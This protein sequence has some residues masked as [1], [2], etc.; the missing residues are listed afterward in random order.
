MKDFV[1]VS[2]KGVNKIT[3]IIRCLRSSQIGTLFIQLILYMLQG[4]PMGLS[5]SIPII[6][7]SNKISIE[8]L[9]FFSIVTLPFSL[10]IL[11]API[12]DCLYFPQVGR[13]KCWLIPTQIACGLLMIFTGFKWGFWQWIQSESLIDRWVEPSEEGVAPN[14]MALSYLFLCYYFLMATQDIAVDAW[15]VSMLSAGNEGLASTMNTIGQS[16]GVFIGNSLFVTFK[17]TEFMIPFTNTS[18]GLLTLGNFTGCCG[19]LMIFVS[20]L[21]IFKREECDSTDEDEYEL[22]GTTRKEKIKNAYGCLWKLAQLSPIKRLGFVLIVIQLP[23]SC[24]D[25]LTSLKLIE[26]GISKEMMAM[27]SPLN[28]VLSFGM[29]VIISGMIYGKS[30]TEKLLSWNKSMKARLSL[31]PLSCGLVKFVSW[32]SSRSLTGEVEYSGYSRV[33]QTMYVI[34]TIIAVGLQSFMFL[35]QMAI[36]NEVTDKRIGAIY[37]TFLNTL[38]NIGYLI[39]GIFVYPLLSFMPLK[40]YFDPFYSL[41]LIF[42][43]GGY[44][45]T[46]PLKGT[47]TKIGNY[48]VKEWHIDLDSLKGEVSSTTRG[49][50]IERDS[51][52]NEGTELRKRSPLP[53]ADP[54]VVIVD[55]EKVNQ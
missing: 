47:V 38:A 52:F 29:P 39:T 4:L 18:I 21:L 17:D 33:C 35:V 13:R 54:S 30:T 37:M 41:N 10:K 5:T 26:S 12:V 31:I 14:V 55:T 6:L 49:I 3:W 24:V 22:F 23:F 48:D 28:M 2:S 40:M 1:S 11:W 45:A 34:Y 51:T 9:G 16:V 8:D 36:F 7:V 43:I 42:L 19:S 27:L 15:A 53:G 25:R 32:C 44:I 50:E 46:K 20:L